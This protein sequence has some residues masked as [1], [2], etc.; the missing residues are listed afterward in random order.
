MILP[1]RPENYRRLEPA[2]LPIDLSAISG[3]RPPRSYPHL[4]R[5]AVPPWDHQSPEWLA[6]GDDLMRMN[7]NAEVG[8]VHGSP[9][10]YLVL[11]PERLS[12]TS[13]AAYAQG[14][15]R[16]NATSLGVVPLSGPCR[17]N[18]VGSCTTEKKICRILP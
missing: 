11:L 8:L 18:C 14:V 9:E 12:G 15:I 5:F 7:G 2:R 4:D 3:P 10:A 1:P 13:M 6:I 16:D 17:F